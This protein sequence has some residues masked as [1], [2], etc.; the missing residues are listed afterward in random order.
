MRRR[1]PTRAGTYSRQ[2]FRAPLCLAAAM[3]LVHL[4]VADE[5]HAA[6]PFDPCYYRVRG[7]KPCPGY[8]P[9]WGYYPTCWRRWPHDA[10]QCPPPVW[11]PFDPFESVVGEVAP[12][13]EELPPP[14]D[15]PP[16]PPGETLPPDV[17]PEEAGPG[18]EAGPAKPGAVPEAAVPEAGAPGAA[19]RL[20]PA[21]SAASARTV[22]L[23]V[24]RRASAPNPP[25]RSEPMS[26]A[27]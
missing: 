7:L 12:L 20:R 23:P 14:A 21:T 24:L 19:P 3:C 11:P 2:G 10:P 18:N 15:Q 9:G 17:V 26:G 22:R 25:V 27:P 16:I 8:G 5:S 6:N 1:G 13:E 4:G